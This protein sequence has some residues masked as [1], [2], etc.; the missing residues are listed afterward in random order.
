VPLKLVRLIKLYL[1]AT[2]S[3]VRVSKHLSETFPIK[4][5][6]KLCI[7]AIA[8]SFVFE[9]VIRRVQVNQDGLK[10]KGT[11]Q[12]LVYV[13]VV[14]TLG[15]SVYTIMKNKEA[16]L[17]GCKEIGLELNADKTKHMAMS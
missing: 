5:G 11:H 10:L 16:L 9:Y 17:V 6:L 3:R 15:V 12:L 8:F 13:Y 4:N 14:N 2:N 1:N 7:I